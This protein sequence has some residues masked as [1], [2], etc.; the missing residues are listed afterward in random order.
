M[1]SPP[2]FTEEKYPVLKKLH[3]IDF[4]AWEHNVE[5]A[6]IITFEDTKRADLQRR[7]PSNLNPKNDFY[8]AAVARLV[9]GLWNPL[10]VSGEVD[11]KA[12]TS[13][14]VHSWVLRNIDCP[15][16]ILEQGLVSNSEIVQTS[17]AGRS[18][19]PEDIRAELFLNT[20]EIVLGV[21]A[22]H[23]DLTATEIDW[24]VKV[25]TPSVSSRL[26][27]NAAVQEDIRVREGLKAL[28]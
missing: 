14:M 6:C 19:L 17:L 26:A 28:T 16:S 13:P 24:L 10:M 27:G 11:V 23:P 9:G 22:S 1:T 25:A 3:A 12:V 20:N 7:I 5:L 4:I 18:N 21:L 2:R 15:K 8:S